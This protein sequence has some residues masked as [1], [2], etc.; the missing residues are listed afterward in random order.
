[1]YGVEAQSRG[2]GGL[3]A[4]TPF[5][6]IYFPQALAIA[7]Q[8]QAVIGGAGP[9]GG[10]SQGVLPY[11]NIGDQVAGG[12]MAGAGMNGSGT[13]ATMPVSQIQNHWSSVLD[14]HNS[15]APWILLGILVLYGWLHLSVRANAGRK[16]SAALVL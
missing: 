3:A 4:Q 6:D 15:P 16:A 9:G 7:G 12:P 13:A 14:F 1:M 5:Q 2:G 8:G 10:G 11:T